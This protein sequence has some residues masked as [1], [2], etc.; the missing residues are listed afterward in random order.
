MS[1]PAKR[2]EQLIE[3]QLE[4][5]V[6]ETIMMLKGAFTRKV[7][8]TW[9]DPAKS[10]P[11]YEDLRR[12]LCKDESP[13]GYYPACV[14]TEDLLSHLVVVIPIQSFMELLEAWKLV[15]ASY[16]ENLAELLKDEGEGDT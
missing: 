3:E 11:Y 7:S 14:V 4:R 1:V 13:I 16:V 8:S 9:I 5:K 10:R 6:N 2:V 15:N 12:V